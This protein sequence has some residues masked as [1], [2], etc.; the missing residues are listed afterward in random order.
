MRARYISSSSLLYYKKDGLT[1]AIVPLFSVR[2]SNANQ[3]LTNKKTTVRTI[4]DIDIVK[5]KSLIPPETPPGT[6]KPDKP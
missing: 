2:W 4:S 5:I 1:G 6:R 3:Q